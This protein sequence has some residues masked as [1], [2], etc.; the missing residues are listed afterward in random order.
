MCTRPITVF[1]RGSKSVGSEPHSYLVPCGKCC[2]CKKRYQNDWK[3]RIFEQIKDSGNG[4][5]V[6]LTYA[7]ENVPL[8]V[9]TET[10]E[11]NKTVYTF[12]AI[13]LSFSAKYLL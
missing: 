3:I 1:V 13:F 12:H 11:C 5:F 10:G 9:D 4:V 6:T 7:P 2:E 8:L